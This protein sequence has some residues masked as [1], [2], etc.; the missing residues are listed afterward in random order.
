MRQ[1]YSCL[2]IQKWEDVIHFYGRVFFTFFE[3]SSWASC[4]ITANVLYIA[5]SKTNITQPEMLV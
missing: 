3:A 2:V 4:I 1:E 5:S